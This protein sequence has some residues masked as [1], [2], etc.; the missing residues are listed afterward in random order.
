MMKRFAILLSAFMLAVTCA[1]CNKGSADTETSSVEK[2]T[3]ASENVTESE[4]ETE[5]LSSESPAEQGKGQQGGQPIKEMEMNEAFLEDLLTKAE[6]PDSTVKTDAKEED[7]IGLWECTVMM[8]DGLCYSGMFHIPLYATD[9]MEINADK[10]GSRI[11][12]KAAEE[13]VTTELPFTWNFADGTLKADVTVHE[14]I[15]V[16]AAIQM[17]DDGS[18]LIQ[19]TDEEGNQVSAYYRHVDSYTEFDF[20][21]VEFDYDVLFEEN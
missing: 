2:S 10:S 3:E 14:E 9:H 15:T 18:L 1:A 13:P 20:T 4:N 12:I 21:T 11:S 8:K 16:P 19:S 7:F 5:E 6:E 17:T